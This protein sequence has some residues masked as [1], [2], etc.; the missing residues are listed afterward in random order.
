L[1]ITTWARAP[2]PHNFSTGIKK[3]IPPTPSLRKR[4]CGR[5][6]MTKG[7]SICTI[8]QDIVLQEIVLQTQAGMT[9]SS[10]TFRKRGERWG[11]PFRSF[12]NG[13]SK[14]R[15][16]VSVKKLL[17]GGGARFSANKLTPKRRGE[18]AEAAFLQKVVSLR[19]QVSKPWG[20]SGPYDFVLDSGE[21]MWRVQVKSAHCDGK[22]G[23]TV[24]AHGNNQEATYSI[25][26]SMSW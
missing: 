8:L 16:Q 10:P 23:Y 25:A 4:S 5:F 1:R 18:L 2:A 20:E 11:T 21:R 22:S 7:W 15:N 14:K 9:A 6:G 13:T 19:F 17:R 24:H 3:Q 26:I 12:L